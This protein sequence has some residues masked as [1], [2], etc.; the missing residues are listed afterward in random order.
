MMT[1][2][3]L[4]P[5]RRRTPGQTCAPDGVRQRLVDGMGR[6]KAQLAYHTAMLELLDAHPGEDP[7]SV[8][9]ALTALH[10]Y[11]A[12]EAIQEFERALVRLENG[13]HDPDA[14]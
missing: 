10:M 3:S 5:A 14:W 12:V 13:R 9:R 2:E 11:R 1:L 8:D 6:W 7:T 4:G